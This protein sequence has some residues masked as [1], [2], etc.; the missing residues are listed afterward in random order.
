M[1]LDLPFLRSSPSP[2]PIAPAPGRVEFVRT[3]RARRYILRVG[4]DGTVRVTIPRRGSRGE[5]IRFMRQHLAWITRER[6]R[7]SRD[8][9]PL[10]WTDGSI[11]LLDG[12]PEIISVRAVSNGLV[13]TYGGRAVPVTDAEDVRGPIERDLRRL[14]AERLIPRLQGLAAQ[15]QVTF[16]KATIRN[17]RSRWGSCSRAGAIA[18]NLRLV[19]MPQAVCDYVMIH[20]LMHV[21]EQN[22]GPRFWSLVEQ[23]CPS[24]R[25]SERWLRTQGRSLF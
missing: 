15:L 25:E 5:A 3:P 11:I 22:H 20:E 23:S 6:A 24:F 13:A 17:Q 12:Q 7:V 1:Q 9:V 4:P 2:P 8:L 21:K 16:T 10:R 19:Q 18:L 14:A